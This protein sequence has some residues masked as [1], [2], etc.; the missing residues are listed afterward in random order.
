MVILSLASHCLCSLS[1]RL[2]AP[3]SPFRRPCQAFLLPPAMPFSPFPPSFPILIYRRPLPSP[4]FSCPRPAP[5]SAFL[6]LSCQKPCGK[7]RNGP[8]N[9]GFDRVCKVGMRNCDRFSQ[10]SA[11]FLCISL[12]GAD[13]RRTFA[14]AIGTQATLALTDTPFTPP[15]RRCGGS[16]EARCNCS[17][18]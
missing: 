3:F 7:P 2:R 8:K 16:R 13:I 5:G 14:L 12:R 17:L 6:P 11:V 1:R 15:R 9:G 4:S 18:K 10:K